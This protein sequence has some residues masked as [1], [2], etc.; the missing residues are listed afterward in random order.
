MILLL[1]PVAP[2][3]PF[4]SDDVL[5]YLVPTVVTLT[6]FILGL[7]AAWFKA[8]LERRRRYKQL[9]S[10]FVT[11]IPNLAEPVG[12]LIANCNDFSGRLT[13]SE[14]LS[15]EAMAFIPL[16]AEKLA[17]RDLQELIKAFLYN[18]TGNQSQ[19]NQQLYYMVSNLDYLVN[20]GPE[21]TD[22]YKEHYDSA[23]LLLKD[24]NAA[25]IKLSDLQG[26]VFSG[27]RDKSE[28]RINMER[29]LRTTIVSWTAELQANPQNTRVTYDHLVL[30]N[31]QL[32]NGYFN[33][34][35]SE[36]QDLID[37]ISELHNVAIIYRQWRAAHDGYATIF[38]NYGVKLQECYERLQASVDYF[39]HQT[40]V[41]R[42]TT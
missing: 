1:K 37:F 18:S 42:I 14:R 35:H 38:T 13:A 20:L 8:N 3:V 32:L 23:N 34:T 12:T 16:N 19:N 5:K 39:G 25:F 2:S 31:L 22:K 27:Q 21:M 36:E 29:Q 41:K 40:R 9:R 26:K 17:G 6:V 15:A 24:W 11:W 7:V 10:L 33:A 4:F 28:A 30:P